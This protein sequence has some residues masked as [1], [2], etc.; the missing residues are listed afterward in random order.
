MAGDLATPSN[1]PISLVEKEEL[2]EASLDVNVSQWSCE[3]DSLRRVVRTWVDRSAWDRRLFPNPHALTIYLEF[4]LA[5]G[6]TLERFE[7][8]QCE[9]DD[10]RLH[11]QT[12]VPD[13]GHYHWLR[14]PIN[15]LSM[16]HRTK[17]LARTIRR[18]LKFL[19]L[20]YIPLK[21]FTKLWFTWGHLGGNANT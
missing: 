13:D 3:K 8:C 19:Q 12:W 20:W 5:C 4:V 6:A 1:P 9:N 11:C 7:K 16:E 2:E 15:P 14:S 10:V 18:I 21:L 17:Y